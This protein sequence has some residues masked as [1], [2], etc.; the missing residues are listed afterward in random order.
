ME[1]TELEKLKFLF[2][3]HHQQV[4]RHRDKMYDIVKIIS[5]LFLIVSGWFITQEPKLDKFSQIFV[6]LF[7]VT[8]IIAGCWAI[9]DKNRSFLENAGVI[10]RINRKLQL[11]NEDKELKES[12]YPQKWIDYGRKGKISGVI[13]FWILIILT[14][15]LAITVV[16]SGS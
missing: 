12:I 9:S 4:T 5:G 16:I 11:F 7:I 1:K 3:E 15:L 2:H 13:G 14:G 6:V 8:M 10:N